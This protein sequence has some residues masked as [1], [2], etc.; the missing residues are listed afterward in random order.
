MSTN[1]QWDIV[2]G[3]GITALA[4][5]GGRAV[6]SRRPDR[7]INDPFAMP[8]FEAAKSEIPLPSDEDDSA[9]I[10]SQMTG[11]LAVRTRF[12]DEF[13]EQAAANGAQ[14]AVI[15]ASG[16]DARAF[17]LSWPENFRVFEIDQPLVLEF[18][19]KVLGDLDATPNC[20]HHNVPVDLRDDWATALKDAGFDT[21][22][23]TAWLAEGLLPYLPPEA[24]AKL[25]ETVH[26]FSAPGSR[27]SI[28]SISGVNSA[29]SSSPDL[30]QASQEWGINVNELFSPED[31]P[32]PE[33]T[34][35]H[36]GWTTTAESASQVS[37]R[38]ERDITGFA[39]VMGQ[40]S[41][42]LTATLPA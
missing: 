32:D 19:D 21:T 9:E 14:Q 37:T 38:Y 5:A 26:A 42:F 10:W 12:F 4:V 1:Q 29:I 28:E 11:Y 17:R 3:V 35:K 7:L 22:V 31:R 30:E 18:K 15:L 40:N 39:T 33:D 23:R 8:L 2:S 27:I 6:E 36:L 24:E 20:G 13:F 25:L 16:L 41:Q 34:L